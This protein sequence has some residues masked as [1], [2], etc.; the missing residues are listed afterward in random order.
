MI[1]ARVAIAGEQCLLMPERT[2]LHERTRTLLAADLHLG[3]AEAIASSG[4]PMPAGIL[5]RQLA[6][7]ATAAARVRA[8]LIIILGDLLHAP[9][10][11]TPVVIE[12]VAAWQQALR[13]PWAIVPGNHDR[14]ISRVA[15]AWNLEILAPAHD[16]GWA[17]LTHAPATVPGKT[18][19]CGHIH[20]IVLAKTASDALRLPAFVVTQREVILPAFSVF[21]AGVRHLDPEAAYYAVADHRVLPITPPWAMQRRLVAR[22]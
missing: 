10:G 3:K 4:A 16:A 1:D 15:R 20:P 12:T 7:L 18:V 21:T 19:I 14:G 2:L 22:T 9:A 17:V 6:D 8:Q 13:I 11:I 5:E